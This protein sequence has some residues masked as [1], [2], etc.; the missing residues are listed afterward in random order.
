VDAGAVDRVLSHSSP[1]PLGALRAA[2]AR[3][4][5]V[6]RG[7]PDSRPALWGPARWAGSGNELAKGPGH[8]KFPCARARSA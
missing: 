2:S 4:G 5:V 6:G 3:L 1:G 8:W 7:Q